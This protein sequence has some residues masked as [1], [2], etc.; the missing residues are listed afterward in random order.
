MS[1]LVVDSSAVVSALVDAGPEGNWIR[2]QLAM[3]SL[4]APDLVLVEACSVIRR[5]ELSG[6][7]PR[8]AAAAAFSDLKA[9]PIAV[10]PFQLL[11]DRSWELRGSVTSYDAAF[12]ALAERLDAPLLTLDRKLAAAPGPRCAFLTPPGAGYVSG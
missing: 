6:I 11:A 4:D 7:V 9:L 8:P 1:Q 12:V 3:H 2:G 10:W 5:L